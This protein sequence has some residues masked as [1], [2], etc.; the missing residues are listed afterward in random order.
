M[1][2]GNSPEELARRYPRC[3]QNQGMNF[4]SQSRNDT[5]QS[6]I[7]IPDGWSKME[8]LIQQLDS[9]AA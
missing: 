8:K 1:L 9:I 5:D 2:W 6:T 7:S 3:V 4:L